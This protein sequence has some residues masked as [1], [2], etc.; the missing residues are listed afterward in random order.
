M[1]E[2][3]TTRLNLPRW[4]AGG[5]TPN[6]SEFD[7]AMVELEARATRFVLWDS[8]GDPD[9]IP[10]PAAAAAFANTLAYD[11]NTGAV[12]MCVDT[13]GAGGYAWVAPPPAALGAAAG[14]VPTTD[15]AGGW[16][17]ADVSSAVV[18]LGEFVGDGVAV[19]ATF[20]PIPGDYDH[21]FVT[22]TAFV[23]PVADLRLRCNN[24]AGDEYSVP[25]ASGQSLITLET[26]IDSSNYATGRI[27]FP[28]SN[29][30]THPKT[31]LYR[32]NKGQVSGAAPTAREVHGKFGTGI[33]MDPI[34]R[35]D[36]FASNPFTNKTRIALYG[37]KG[38]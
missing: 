20:D 17:L 36:L 26:S 1:A 34:T 28:Y 35:V 29:V 38:A 37:V 33:Y 9:A 22:L 25:G 32:G 8:T 6:R 3:R 13:T 14:L 31:I 4:T 15:G 2:S 11:R 27:D 5:D 21:L 12:S 7:D 23:N 18:P 16:T 10:R 30:S 24:R 19:A